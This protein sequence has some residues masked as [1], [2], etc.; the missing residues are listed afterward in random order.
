MFSWIWNFLL[1]ICSYQPI[2]LVF[3]MCSLRSTTVCMLSSCKYATTQQQLCSSSSSSCLSTGGT[4]T[5]VLVTSLIVSFKTFDK[6]YM[7]IWD[8]SLVVSL[9]RN[10]KHPIPMPNVLHGCAQSRDVMYEVSVDPCCQALPGP[11]TKE[12]RKT[13]NLPKECSRSQCNIP[14]TT[15]YKG[16]CKAVYTAF[17]SQ[18]VF[19]SHTQST[20]PVK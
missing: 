3:C 5:P 14:F 10:L 17:V 6:N 4:S 16:S 15:H 18:E 13:I 7:Y 2:R 20:P 9:H 8:C 11:A 19:S 12:I 1:Q